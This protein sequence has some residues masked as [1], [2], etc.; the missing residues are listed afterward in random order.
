MNRC[1]LFNHLMLLV[2]S[3]DL[4]SP[5][6]DRERSAVD[7]WLASNKIIHAMRDHPFHADLILAGMWG[8]RPSNNRALAHRIYMKL[9][10]AS[11]IGNYEGKADQLFLANEVWPL[12][13]NDS[14]IHASFHCKRF[15]D[16]SQPFPTK[17]PSILGQNIFVGC[18]KPCNQ[19]QFVFDSCPF[20]CR[21]QNHKDWIY[22]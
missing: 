9:Q 18:V 22:C 16:N 12:V 20:A 2:L 11:L 15:Q 8:F 6:T 21:P 1:V 14:I 13:K 4:D 7:E 17:R 10:N 19:S 3:R 5:L